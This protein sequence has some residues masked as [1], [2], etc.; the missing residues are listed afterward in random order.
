L[1]HTWLCSPKKLIPIVFSLSA[2][3]RDTVTPSAAGAR[4]AAHQWSAGRQASRGYRPSV[5]VANVA[6]G[7]SPGVDGEGDAGSFAAG[8]LG[9]FCPQGQQMPLPWRSGPEDG[10]ERGGEAGVTVMED[11][12]RGHPCVV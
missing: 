9:A 4:L 1:R 2:G 10:V 6:F 3:P 8:G 12:L 5:P 11:E 7:L